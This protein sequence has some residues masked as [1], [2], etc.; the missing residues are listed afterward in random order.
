[1][2]SSKDAARLASGYHESQMTAWQ[3]QQW[4]RSRLR[5]SKSNI[6]WRVRQLL[7]VG[8]FAAWFVAFAGCSRKQLTP[9]STVKESAPSEAQPVEQTPT[10]SQPTPLEHQLATEKWHGDLDEIRKRRIL[11]VLAA[12]NKLGFYFN[13]AQMLIQSILTIL[14]RTWNDVLFLKMIEARRPR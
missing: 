12:P 6:V 9:Q 2:P 3:I 5:F 7:L 13:G 8:S 10:A 11:R 14:H 4:L 1:V